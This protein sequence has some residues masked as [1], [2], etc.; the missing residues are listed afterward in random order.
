[1]AAAPRP[2]GRRAR[3]RLYRTPAALER[4]PAPSGRAVAIGAFDGVHVGHQEILRR[5]VGTAAAE[6]RASTVFSFEPMPAEV[7]APDDPP[8]RLT[9]FRERFEVFEAMGLEEFFCPSFRT[10]K[11]LAPEVFIEALLHRALDTR[12]LVVGH[13]FRFGAGRRGGLEDLERASRRYG[14]D[15]TVVEPVERAGRRVSSTAIRAALAAGDL[16][17]ARVMLGRDYSMSGRVIRGQ[18]LGRGLGYPT[19]N[20]SL[21]RRRSPIDGIFAVRVGG[22]DDDGLLDGV[23]SIGTRPTVGGGVALL[24]VLIFDFDRDIY[25]EHITVH[26][27]RRLREERRFPSLD[28]LKAQMRLDV[29]EARAALESRIA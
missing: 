15:V 6:G 2:G 7:M 21:K 28:A 18:G 27:V 4:C 29:A 19:A 3:L 12:H 25:G 5:V 22:L 10:L 8:A 24:E 9:R 11:N 20:V 23:A 17:A 16:D 13:D 14:F 1:M 26:F